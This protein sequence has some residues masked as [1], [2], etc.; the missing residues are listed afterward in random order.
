MDTQT[1]AGAT[2]VK[3][4]DIGDFKDVPIIDVHVKVGDP[5]N[6]E[7]PLITLESDK[8]T[9]DVPAPSAGTVRQVLVKVGDRVSE[10]TPIVVL[11]GNEEGAMQQPTSAA[12]ATGTLARCS[13]PARAPTGRTTTRRTTADRL[14]Q[15]ASGRRAN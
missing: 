3:V 1:S 2:E 7:D 9:M 5:V 8:A 14:R 6:A 12:V 11:A 4:P 15:R 13:R 10:G